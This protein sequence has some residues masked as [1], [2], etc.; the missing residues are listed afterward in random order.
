ML[1]VEREQ[2]RMRSTCI[3]LHASQQMHNTHT[4]IN[5]YVGLNNTAISGAIYNFDLE[6]P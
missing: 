2:T 3:D 4:I 5:M 1:Y 6:F